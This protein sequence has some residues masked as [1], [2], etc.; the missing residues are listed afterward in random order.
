MPKKPSADAR[1]PRILRFPRF[2]EFC[3]KVHGFLRSFL[4]SKMFKNP[5]PAVM[6]AHARAPSNFSQ[7]K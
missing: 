4:P 3:I 2:Q 5:F 1:A 6:R 7:P